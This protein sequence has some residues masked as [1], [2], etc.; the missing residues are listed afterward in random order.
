MTHKNALIFGLLAG[1]V[2]GYM[3][4]DKLVNY[5]PWQFVASKLSA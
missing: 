1:A 3:F 2:I 4:A 5:Q